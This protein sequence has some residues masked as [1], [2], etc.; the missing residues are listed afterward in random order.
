MT[1]IFNNYFSFKSSK[2]EQYNR[3]RKIINIKRNFKKSKSY[4]SSNNIMDPKNL[5]SNKLIQ[6]I[7]P[8]RTLSSFKSPIIIKNNLNIRNEPIFNKNN[9]NLFP[10]SYKEVISPNEDS[11]NSLSISKS[12]TSSNANIL[13][14]NTSVNEISKKL[15]ME[16]SHSLKKRK[17]IFRLIIKNKIEDLEK[18]FKKDMKENNYNNIINNLVF[19]YMIKKCKKT[20]NIA[21]EKVN[22]EIYT[23]MSRFKTDGLYKNLGD[24]LPDIFSLIIKIRN[25][26][27]INEKNKKNK[28]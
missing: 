13:K 10:A 16:N 23:M 27:I 20:L 8:S 18:E 15:K 17:K 11:N 25:Q 4:F 6:K 24:G 14:L 7:I 12:K 22:H 21:D 2:N 28:K 1:I 19:K 9:T 5:I 3:K 26:I